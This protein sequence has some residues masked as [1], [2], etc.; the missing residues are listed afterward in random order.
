MAGLL[1]P[2]KSGLSPDGGDL[3]A[4]IDTVVGSVS[5]WLRSALAQAITDGA[6]DLHLEPFEDRVEVRSRVDGELRVLPPPPR[7]CGEA[8]A[9]RIKV[10]A[11]LD[12]SERRLPQ[13]GRFSQMHEQRNIDLRV[14][15][16]PTVSG[17]SVVIRILDREVR[18]LHL[19]SLGMPIDVAATFRRLISSAHGLILVTGPTGSGKTTTLYSALSE[20]NRDERKLLTVEDPVEYDL[21][22]VVQTS[23]NAEVGLSF[24]SA[25][26][27]FLRQDPDVIMVGEIRDEETAQMALQAALTGH[28]VLS[29]LHTPDSASAVVRLVEMGAPSFL[30]AAALKGVV[31]QRLLRRPC[32]RCSARV[33]KETHLSLPGCPCGGVGFQGRTGVYEVMEIDERLRTLIQRGD[34]A[35]E[36][37]QAAITYGMRSLRDEGLR[38][39]E[40]G[41]VAMQDVIEHL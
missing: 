11:G 22:G 30:I 41:V 37:R 2:P 10:L 26:R 3:T 36:L 28:L 31:A 12:V 24:A 38:C 19:D 35:M 8:L 14:S 16:L 4:S 33:F 13:D 15:T 7:G 6:S 21:E 5:G 20:L 34:S 18:R 39:A 17:E 27:S 40:A 9:S 25:L 23:V 1:V 32:P 29:T